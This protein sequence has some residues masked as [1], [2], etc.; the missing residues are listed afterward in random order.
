MK[1]V[2]YKTLSSIASFP[3]RKLAKFIY[4]SDIRSVHEKISLFSRHQDDNF[5]FKEGLIGALIIAEDHRYFWH[6]GIDFV[7]IL[8]AVIRNFFGKLEGASTIE[9]QLVRVIMG[10]YEISFA[11][12]I[13]EI[14][15]ASTLFGVFEKDEIAIIYLERAYYGEGIIGARGLIDCSDFNDFSS[16]KYY[17]AWIV[18][19]L[20]YPLGSRHSEVNHQRRFARAGRILAKECKLSYWADG[21]G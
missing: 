11:R 3:I 8:R 19:H 5:R 12:K 10:R 20:K 7:G 2:A 15:L 9:Q 13:K 17:C 1:R 18:A 4:S 16:K 6:Q 14:L 21:I